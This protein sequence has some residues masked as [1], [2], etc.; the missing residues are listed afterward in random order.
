MIDQFNM[1]N[2][3]LLKSIDYEVHVA[4]N[5]EKGNT[6]SADRILKLKENLKNLNVEYFQIDFSRNIYRI[7]DNVKSYKQVKE[8]LLKNKYEFLH[9]HSPI[10]GVIGRLAGYITHTKVIYTAHGFHFY[11]GA[12][13]KNWLLYFPVEWICAYLTDILITINTEDYD[14]AKRRLKAKYI[15][16]V[17]G[18][19]LDIDKFLSVNL[20]KGEKKKELNIRKEDFVFVSIGELNSNKN[21]MSIILALAELKKEVSLYNIKYLICG[22]GDLEK[23]LKKIIKENVLEDTVKLLGFRGDVSEIYKVSDFFIFPSYREGLSVA[24]MEAMANKLP[25]MCSEIRGNID[26]IDEKGGFLFKPDNHEKIKSIL[27][28]IIGNLENEVYKQKIKNMGLYNFEKVQLFS[29]VKVLSDLK[30]IYNFIKSKQ[31]DKK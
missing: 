12:P 10:G 13:L 5:F 11:K 19:G 9:C 26:L 24:L 30:K 15:E 6:C 29:K 20:D 17:R 31:F 16:Y 7:C 22:V 23:T 1:S 25:V 21:H 14:F 28:E 3:K 27:K 4:C 8:I 2:I 18:I